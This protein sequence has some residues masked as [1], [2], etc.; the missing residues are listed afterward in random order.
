MPREQAL[1]ENKLDAHLPYPQI[2]RSENFHRR[3]GVQ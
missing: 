1:P 3:A 2:L